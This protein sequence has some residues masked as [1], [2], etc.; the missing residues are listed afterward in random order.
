MVIVAFVAVVVSFVTGT[1][2]AD[3]A[4]VALD[5]EVVALVTNA[6][7]SVHFLLTAEAELRA[8]QSTVE[9]TVF[10]PDFPVAE[11]RPAI[12]RNRDRLQTAVNESFTTPAYPGES[13]AR[14][15]IDRQLAVVDAEVAE[16]LAL[17]EGGDRRSAQ[18]AVRERL[19]PS[20]ARLQDVIAA[21]IE[22]NLS[23]GAANAQRIAR[24]RERARMIAFVAD[25]VSIL[26]ALALALL[27]LRTL[28][29]HERLAAEHTA[30]VERRAEELELFSGR[31]AHDVL[32]PLTAL[33]LSLDMAERRAGDEGLRVLLG[34][35]RSGLQR[36]R[37]IV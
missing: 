29:A 17:V 30:L 34:R 14:L 25:G 15:E 36:V 35:G 7:P 11:A 31:I 6:V 10:D 4:I 5:D 12:Q 21:D 24:T 8:L 3:R 26:L 28:R 19:S 16:V 37:Q 27:S 9:D 33:G 20:L 32:S 18:V 2:V 22:V 23:G 1:V 13:A